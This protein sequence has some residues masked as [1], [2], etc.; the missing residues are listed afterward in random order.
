M[1]GSLLQFHDVRYKWTCV[2]VARGSHEDLT[3]YTSVLEAVNISRCMYAT[4]ALWTS[5]QEAVQ[6]SVQSVIGLH[7]TF[8]ATCARRLG[9]NACN[10]RLL[11]LAFDSDFEICYAAPAQAMPGD[12][13]EATG[14][15]EPF[16]LLRHS[17][18]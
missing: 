15:L 6:R 12:E 17:V 5:S 13:A 4:L 10:K 2:C 9:I 1:F 14:A 16:S 3:V 18:I 8:S 11:G 7:I